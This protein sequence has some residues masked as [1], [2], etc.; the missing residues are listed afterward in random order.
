MPM[1]D[2]TGPDGKGPINPNVCPVNRSNNV[3]GRG[4]KNQFGGQ[5]GLGMG[6][7][8]RTRGFRFVN[9]NDR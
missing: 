6:R 3:G 8:L 4:R 2:G 9:Q 5:N 1:Q 7:K